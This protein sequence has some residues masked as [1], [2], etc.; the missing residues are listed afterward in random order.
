M[1][2]SAFKRTA[3]FATMLMFLWV[4]STAALAIEAIVEQPRSFG[5]VIGDLVTQRVLLQANGRTFEP[6]LWKNTERVSVWFERRPPSIEARDDGSRWL[7]V[8]Y[9]LINAPQALTTVRIPTWELASSSTTE[10]LQIPEW[11]ISIGPLTPRAAFGQ[12]D[13]QELRSDRQTP[14]IPTNALRRQFLA[15]LS[16][17]LLTS[18]AWL[19]WWLWRNRRASES[20]PFARALRELRL[21]DDAQPAA[22]HALHRAFDATAGRVVN[23]TS[24]ESFFEQAPH[25]SAL[26]PEI[27]QFFDCS[28]RRF[29][30]TEPETESVSIRALCMRLRRLERRHEQ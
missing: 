20:Q 11:P 27:E 30:A 24:L 21:T 23:R 5:Y 13:L 15:W 1:R 4:G 2:C 12:G 17:L 19:G 18:V 3:A 25:F 10:T 16:A 14:A 28:A 29:F 9:Q 6:E 8:T 26:R 22:W 7:V